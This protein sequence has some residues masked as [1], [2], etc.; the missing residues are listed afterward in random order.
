MWPLM[1]T[2]SSW[3]GAITPVCSRSS[4]E[5]L[6]QRAATAPAMLSAL[7]CATPEPSFS[8]AVRMSP[9]ML[10]STAFFSAGSRWRMISSITAVRMPA[11]CSWAKGLPASTASSCF[12]SPTRTTLG[13][14]RVLA[15]LSRSRVC[16]V[17]ASEPS[18]TTSTV[19]A[20]ASRIPR[21]PLRVSLPSATPALRARN[22]C[23][24]SLAMPD[25]A[26]RVCT[27]EADGARPSIR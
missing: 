15:I 27:A 13:M 17:E 12:S 25:S 10:A 21:A 23:R 2:R 26:A 1:A 11:C 4:G 9:A 5:S 6:S 3:L 24:V 8:K 16:T 14:R 19:F 7:T 22:P 20:K 18:S